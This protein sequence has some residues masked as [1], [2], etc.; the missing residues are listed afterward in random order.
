M[1]D[2]LGN[3]K[4][5]LK[6]QLGT[7]YKMLPDI[8]YF[9]ITNFSRTQT[10]TYDLAKASTV[11][12]SC[13]IILS[14]Q[15][16][17]KIRGNVNIL[18]TKNPAS[19]YPT[20]SDKVFILN[21]KAPL[22]SKN[23]PLAAGK[24]YFKVTYPYSPKVTY[25]IKAEVPI[26]VVPV[27]VVP[28]PVVPVPVPVVPVADGKKY[29]LIVS[30]SDYLYISDLSFC[31]EDAIAWYDYLKP[32]GYEVILLGDKT[33]Q[34]GKYT[35]NGLATEANIRQNMKNIASTLKSGDTFAFIS[36][37]HGSGDGSGSSFLC[38]LDE[39]GVS[40]GEYYDNELAL[41]IKEMTNK[42]SNVICF[43]DNCY[44]GGL[45]D[46]TVNAGEGKVCSLSTCT[47]NGFG[48]DVSQYKHGAWTYFFL[49]KVLKLANAPKTLGEAYNLAIKGYP[50]KGGDLPQINGNKTLMF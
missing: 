22:F 3:N 45:L 19:L 30:V 36:S 38:C 29:A 13:G 7:L 16:L 14:N 32:L 43:F 41:D 24:W 48:Y 17:Q 40:K 50:Y 47:D 2:V 10:W 28:V 23:M 31:D 11:R 15:E 4:A 5:K 26:P 37:G 18:V 21:K 12:L 49:V 27:P 39:D 34:Y 20:S 1:A 44:S 25:K 9:G 46:E 33:S 6:R 35:K 42:G 8:Y